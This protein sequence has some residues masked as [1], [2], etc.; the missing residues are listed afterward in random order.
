MDFFCFERK[1]IIELDGS[2]HAERIAYDEAR[3]N[4]LAKR[5]LK[6]LRFWNDEVFENMDGVLERI[7]E[8]GLQISPSPSPSRGEGK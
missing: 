6:V 4:Y 5:G 1:L 8:V 7:R 3:S 2:Q